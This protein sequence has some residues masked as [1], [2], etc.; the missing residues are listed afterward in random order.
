M[1]TLRWALLSVPLAAMALPL[2]ARAQS[3]DKSSL[4]V[5][6]EDEQGGVVPEAAVS[7]SNPMTGVGREAVSGPAGSATLT[8]LP[9]TGLYQVTVTKAGFAD[10]TAHDVALRAG[11]TATIRV[12]LP[13]A[14]GQSE[15]TVYG[16]TEGVRSDPKLGIRL[17]STGIDETPILGRKSTTLPLLNSAFR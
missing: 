8:A 11:E 7:L 12:K 16:T 13:V 3:P 14:G 1:R 4:V 15:V 5:V 2:P 6:V 10:A 17:E 9:L